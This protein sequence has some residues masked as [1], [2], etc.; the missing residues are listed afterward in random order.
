M[1]PDDLEQ[2]VRDCYRRL[3]LRLMEQNCTITTM[4][5]ATGGM[6]AS[7]LCDTEGTSAIFPGA[8]VT[9]SNEAK[10]RCGVPAQ[11]IEQHSV[12]SRPTAAAMA[13]ACRS[14]YDTHIGVGVTG[15]LGNTDQANPESSVPG[16]LYFAFSFRAGDTVTHFTCLP[17]QKSRHQWKLAAADVVGSALWHHL[18]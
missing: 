15:T 2:Q 11:V 9:Y 17:P 10:L 16:E 7:L 4:E 14:F 8:F 5:S 1:K 18:F 6:V 13:Q 3:T 12:Y